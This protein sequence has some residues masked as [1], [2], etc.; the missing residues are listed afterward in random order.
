M[1]ARS[2]SEPREKDRLTK[3][4]AAGILMADAV[5]M[6]GATSPEDSAPS[7][8]PPTAVGTA[9]AF[10]LDISGGWGILATEPV[11]VA[12]TPVTSGDK[13]PAGSFLSV[14][15]LELLFS[16]ESGILVVEPL[17][18]SC[19]DAIVSPVGR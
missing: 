10:S 11:R 2:E 7:V 9:F 15:D 3:N 13:L 5:L 18:R 19:W 8:M 17:C 4:A 6:V 1:K 14:G 12:G 16:L